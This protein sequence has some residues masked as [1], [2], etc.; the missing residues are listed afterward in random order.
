MP[1]PLVGQVHIATALTTIAT[2]YIQ[3]ESNYIAD[4][5]FPNVPVEH[6]ADKYFIFRKGDF[7]RDQAQA[8]ADATESAG[9]GFNMDTGSYAASVWAFHK[10][11]GD[12]VRRNADPAVD[13]DVATTKLIMQTLMI[14]RDRAF[15]AKYLANGVWGTD[16]T[17]VSANPS[18]T[19]TIYWNDD[20]NGDPFTDISTGQTTILQ[21][22]G[23]MPN[24]FLISWNVYQ[25]LRKHPLVIDRIKYT[26]EAFA[27]T[28]TPKLLA[29]LF[30]VDEVL[31]SK[32]VYNS[33][34]EATSGSGSDS[35]AF[36]ANKDALL[37]Y[38]PQAPG[39]M[40][41]SAGYTFSWSGLSQGLN[42]LGIRISQIPMPW[43]GLNTIRTEGEMAYDM[44]VIGSDLGYHFSGIVQ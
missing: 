34:A 40:I 11:V 26:T 18:A 25:A 24:L 41:P 39:L 6:Q 1:Q 35:F 14:R 30:D 29:Q 20:A 19:Q 15:V 38:R 3:D 12:Q 17:G 13:I 10:D 44:Q 33:G 5:A 9:G 32:A 7:F 4:K 31:V 43:L 28:V 22:T 36:I 2:A 21:N 8:R 42:T 16:I 27:G 37:F 23:Q